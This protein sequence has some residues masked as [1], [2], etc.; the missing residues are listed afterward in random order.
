MWSQGGVL[1]RRVS[2][3]YSDPQYGDSDR[4]PIDGGELVAYLHKFVCSDFEFLFCVE[5]V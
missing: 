2:A 4:I 3:L 5:K 1:R